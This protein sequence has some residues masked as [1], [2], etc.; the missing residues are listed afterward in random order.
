[1]KRELSYGTYISESGTIVCPA[2]CDVHVHFREPGRP[3]KETIRT[4]SLAAAAAGYSCVCTMPNLDPAPDSPE[5]LEVQLGI[6]R[7]DA[8]IKVLPYATITL[9]RKGREIVDMAVLKPSVA[10]F[11]DDGSGVQDPAVMLKA[12]ERAAECGAVIAAHCE[13]SAFGTGPES[14]WRQIGRDLELAAKTG[15]KYHVC[16]ISTKESVDLIR[17]AKDRGTDVTCE[18]APHYL[19]L[20][21]EDVI[22]S[23]GR[24]KMNPP[25]RSAQDRKA[26]LEGL[27]DG[28]IDMI[29]TDHA[30]HTAAEKALGMSGSANGIVG[31]E[32]AF[33]VLYT[34]L[35]RKEVIGLEKL[36]DLMSLSPR[37]RFGI[38]LA[39]DIT[40]FDISTPYRIDSSSF[41][42]KG[43]STPFEGME[44]YGKCLRTLYNG[45]TIYKNT[46]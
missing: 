17:R 11:S 24:F 12:M 23:E 3:D 9:G 16:H 21:E 10:G 27:R 36:V 40:E 28:T 39:D 45:N 2:F 4:G 42:S 29:A 37:R 18:T 22:P 41:L 33:P 8:V 26:L 19:V 5:N 32:T 7:K 31:L 44:V 15:C 20:C 34:Q 30:P 38:E 1:M 35:V 46:I 13:D 14:E 25:L 6:I 43:R